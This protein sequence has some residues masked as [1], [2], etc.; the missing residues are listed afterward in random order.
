M[1]RRFITLFLSVIMVVN[2]CGIET[3]ASGNTETGEIYYNKCVLFAQQDAESIVINT[4][5]LSINGGIISGGNK[6]YKCSGK[7]HKRTNI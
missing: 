1:A 2:L 3:K 5:N 6:Y 4:G 7:E